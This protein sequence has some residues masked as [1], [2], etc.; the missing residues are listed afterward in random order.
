MRLLSRLAWRTVRGLIAARLLLA[1]A[2]GLAPVAVAA[3]TSLLL[4]RLTGAPGPP[5]GTLTA[6]VAGS[7]AVLGLLPHVSSYADAETGR[8]LNRRMLSELV[9]GVNRSRGLANLE[10][11]AMRDRL[12]IAQQAAQG[13]PLQLIGGLIAVVQGTLMVAGFLGSLIAISPLLTLAVAVSAV[14]GLMAQ[15]WLAR[16]RTS[17]VTRTAGRWRRQLFYLFLLTDLRAAKEIRLFGAGEFLRDRMDAEIGEVY[18]QERDV[19]RA[20]LNVGGGLSI[21]TV[22]VSGLALVVGVSRIATGGAG[23]GSLALLT[24]ALVGV[25]GALTGIVGQVA[26]IQQ[27][28]LLFDSFVRVVTAPPDLPEPA[29]AASVV[30]LRRNVTLRDVWFRYDDGHPWVLRGLDLTIPA[31]GTTALVG[32]NGAGK[33]TVVKL[34]CRLYD[35]SRGSVCWDGTDLRELDLVTLRSRITATF[36]DFMNYEL[37]AAENIALGDVTQL[38]SAIAIEAAARSAQVHEVLHGLPAGYHTML[39][40]AFGDGDDPQ[41]GVVLSGGQWQRVALARAI[42]RDRADLLILD[43]PSAGL[44]P[45]AEHEVWQCL[46]RYR[47]GRT[48]LLVSHRLNTVREADHIVVLAAGRVA[49]Q[50]THDELIRRGGAYQRLFALQSAGYQETVAGGRP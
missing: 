50:G 42:I 48:T 45:E 1:A 20:T 25:Q 35:P 31:L 40:R 33:S 34:L 32:L 6:L 37:T 49:E 30:A 10:N 36:Q 15:L 2:A 41:T 47:A 4:N 22:L 19:A 12:H 23:I 14:P 21:L 16:R 3:L 44:D 7:G 27:G 13:V 26:S 28:R 8:R 5:I 46:Q 29:G 43:E 39:T 17:M 9:N 24:A 18:R 38:G 11:P